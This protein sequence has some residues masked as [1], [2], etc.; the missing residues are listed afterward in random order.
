M[1]IRSLSL[2]IGVYPNELSVPK[3]IKFQQIDYVDWPFY[4][5][6]IF[7]MVLTTFGMILQFRNKR[8][9]GGRFAGKYYEEIM[10]DEDKKL[11]KHEKK[12]SKYM[13]I[14]KEEIKK[15]DSDKD[16]KFTEQNEGL[17]MS[18]RQKPKS[19]NAEREDD[20]I[21]NQQQEE[22]VVEEN[23][24]YYEEEKKKKKKKKKKHHHKKKKE[25]EEENNEENY[26]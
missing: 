16:L 22:E 18:K 24:G 4:I 14:Q 23:A 7:I 6:F 1:I 21:E 13:D 19:N 11:T 2:Y 17:E 15:T 26:E 9:I 5:Y 12:K 10:E 8:K 20:D 3:Q 25:E